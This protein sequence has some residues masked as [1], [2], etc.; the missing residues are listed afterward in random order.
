MKMKF[1]VP[2][3]LVTLFFACTPTTQLEKSWVDPSLTPGSF[4]PFNKVLVVASMADESSKRIAEDKIVAQL[5]SGTGVQAY[6][7][8]LPSDT[9][10]KALDIKLKKDGFDG[11]ILMRLKS[12][13]KSVSYVEGT[14]YGGWYGYRYSSPGYYSEDKTYIVETNIYSLETNKL[15]WTGTT[16]SLNPGKLNQMLDAIIAVDKAELVKQGLI[17]N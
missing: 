14:G 9:N 15:L 10:D 1:L 8:L 2:A 16:S 12:V 11:I 13:D 3:V 5:K 7:Y 17:K 4:Q 6:T